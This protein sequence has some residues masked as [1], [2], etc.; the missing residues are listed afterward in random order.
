MGLFGGKKDKSPSEQEQKE[1]Q[2]RLEEARRAMEKQQKSDTPNYS[3]RSPGG[4]S[5][6]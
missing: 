4:A 2:K 3:R 6:G 5:G 1:A